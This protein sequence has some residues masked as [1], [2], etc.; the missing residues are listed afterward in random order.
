MEQAWAEFTKHCIDRDGKPRSQE[1]TEAEWF[2]VL[3]QLFPGKQP[4]QLSPAEWGVMLAEG[5]NH[6]TPF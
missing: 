4:D 1:D 6:I 2:H 5:S 3:A